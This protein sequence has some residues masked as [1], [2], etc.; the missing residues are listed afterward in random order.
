MLD[1]ALG[2]TA[3]LAAALVAIRVELATREAERLVTGRPLA[4]VLTWLA[5]QAVGLLAAAN[6]FWRVYLIVNNRG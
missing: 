5:S 6:L 3:L 1:A 2:L 4:I